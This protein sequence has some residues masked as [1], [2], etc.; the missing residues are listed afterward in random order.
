MRHEMKPR[1]IL[2]MLALAAS[3][4]LSPAG[5]QETEGSASRNYTGPVI[6]MHMH[7]FTIELQGPDAGSGFTNPLT[8]RSYTRVNSPE[9]QRRETYDRIEKYN[10]VK[11]AVSG[12]GTVSWHEADQDRVLIG[13]MVSTRRSTVDELRRQHG[14]GKLHILGEMGPYYEGLRADDPAVKPFFDL[15]EELGIPAAYHLF[16]GGGPGSLYAGG[17]MS[18]IRAANADPMQIEEVL[19]THPTMRIYV[20]HAG[21]PYLE[22]MKA[23]MFAHPQLHVGIAAINWLIPTT[24]FHGFLKGLVDAGYGKRIL[25]G[26]DQMDMPSVMDDAF[27]SIDSAAFL[28]AEQTADIF[29]Y[30]AARFLGLSEEEIA[31]HWKTN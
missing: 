30:N 16:P 4:A 14:E 13:S 17:M 5:A 28:T 26:T 18:R 23:L 1:A 20:M 3:F 19:V 15:A 10:I 31:E 12:S 11:A 25:W 9:E 24:E 8:G 7:A 27:E 29:Y 6:D 2:P 21:W 22:D